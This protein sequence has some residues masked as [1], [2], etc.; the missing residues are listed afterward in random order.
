MKKTIQTLLLAS[1]CT[2]IMAQSMEVPMVYREIDST[3]NSNGHRLYQGVKLS[4][5]DAQIKITNTRTI[6]FEPQLAE[7]VAKD[8]TTS[9]AANCSAVSSMIDSERLMLDLNKK[10]REDMSELYDEARTLTKEYRLAKRQ[11]R[12][13]GVTECGDATFLKEEIDFINEDIATLNTQAGTILDS[14]ADSTT[15]ELIDKMG[16]AQGGTLVAVIS[17]NGEDQAE[18]LKALNPFY[19]F[20]PIPAKNVKFHLSVDKTD[21]SSDIPR[22]IVLD[23]APLDPTAANRMSQS[24]VLAGN[25]SMGVKMTLSR[26]GACSDRHISTARF[27]YDFDAFG[28]VKGY[29]ELN[30]S[31][32]YKRIESTTKKGGL[33]SSK[34]STS[35]DE[36][37]KS[38]EVLKVYVLGDVTKE[39]ASDQQEKIRDHIVSEALRSWTTIQS[40][41]NGKPLKMPEHGEHGAQVLA[42]GVQKLC[43]HIYCQ[44]G[45]VALKAL[46]SI[47]GSNSSRSSVRQNWEQKV[48]YEYNYNTRNT[49]TGSAAT[50]IKW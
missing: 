14:Y 20:K 34:T 1:M 50:L 35:I 38:E 39:E 9:G 30:R 10:I 47:F 18:E 5:E 29:G 17:N 32:F 28:F 25:G 21:V 43:P 37:A 48:K 42:D 33:F 46:D 3:V 13:E 8:R 6:F 22:N 40:L 31:L 11:C 27:V 12:R 16:E 36:A 23:T 45:A 7:V 26:L 4:G 2:P 19:N 44:A 41:S 24:Q 15:N 49:Y